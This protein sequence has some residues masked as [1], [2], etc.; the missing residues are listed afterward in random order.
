MG[1][2]KAQESLP[3]SKER[4]GEAKGKSKG[5]TS[6]RPEKRSHQFEIML[7]KS[8]GGS[9]G[10]NVA[11]LSDGS[12]KIEH[13]GDDITSLMG[14]WNAENP[15]SKVLPGDVIYEVNGAIHDAEKIISELKKN[16]FLACS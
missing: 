5:S 8:K 14:S 13:V 12:L 4:R 11:T 3:P 1:K 2:S 16:Q 6:K 7:D 9:L 15:G 10:I